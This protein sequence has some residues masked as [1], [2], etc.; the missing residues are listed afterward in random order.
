MPAAY[1]VHIPPECKDDSLPCFD[2]GHAM[3]EGTW[4]LPRGRRIVL[5]MGKPDDGDGENAIRLHY[6][7]AP[8][9]PRPSAL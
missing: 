7:E 4:S 6:E 9:R 5:R 2:D 8:N 3:A 1:A